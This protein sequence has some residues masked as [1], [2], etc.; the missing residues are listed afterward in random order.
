MTSDAAV[1]FE[2]AA[3]PEAVESETDRVTRQLRD[4]ILDGVRLPGSK[5]VERDLAAGLGVSR[6]PVRQALQ[7]L[8]AEGLVTARP[9]TWAVVREFTETDIN[10]LL[11]VRSALEVLAFTQAARC[12]AELADGSRA[13]LGAADADRE[14]SDAG[15]VTSLAAARAALEAE[16]AAAEAG[17]QIAAHRA[18][19]DFHEAVTALSGNQL[20]VELEQGLRS[21]MRWLLSQHD[22]LSCVAREH[23]ELLKGIESGDAERVR[24]LALRHLESSRRLLEER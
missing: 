10:D 13:E 3:G 22:D 15:L 18:G 19:A 7:T 8:G 16:I 20:L 23:Q 12:R 17:N 11:E 21:R 6:V 24:K 4:E 5:L 2:L 9:R 1:P 14:D